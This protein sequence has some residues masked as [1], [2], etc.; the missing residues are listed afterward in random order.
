MH[1]PSPLPTQHTLTPREI[2]DEST[3]ARY[4]L[5][6]GSGGKGLRPVFSTQAFIS[7]TPHWSSAHANTSITCPFCAPRAALSA[8]AHAHALSR[9]IFKSLL[10]AV[11]WEE[12][13]SVYVRACGRCV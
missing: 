1:S 3:T 7:A 13:V 12:E 9:H 5:Y 11:C 2:K 10:V 4:S 8:H 6:W